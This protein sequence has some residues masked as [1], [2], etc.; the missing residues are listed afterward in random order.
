[1]KKLI[2]TAMLAALLATSAF[3]ELS[4]GTW[5]R[6]MVAPVA[7]DGEDVVKAYWGN[8]WGGLRNARAS[9]NWTSDDG[10]VGMMYDV[11]GEGSGD[12]G[13]GDYR[14][15]WVK[16]ADWVKIMVGRID[17]GYTMRSD[18]AYGSWN[19]IRPSTLGY[20]EGLT[21][22]LDNRSGLQVELFP[23]EGLQI[24]AHLALP[25]NGGDVDIWRA[26]GKSQ[27]AVGYTIGDIGTIKVGFS[28]KNISDG[29]ID[30]AKEAE[31]DHGIDDAMTVGKGYYNEK[32]NTYG[33]LQAAFDLTAVENMFLTVGAKA[34]FGYG[35]TK[36]TV[37]PAVG[38][39]VGLSDTITL[40]VS[41][42][43]DITESKDPTIKGGVGLDVGL[44]DSLGLNV[45]CRIV[46][47]IENSDFQLSF[48]VGVNY[49]FSSNGTLG[50]GFQGIA[51][52][53]NAGG[54]ALGPTV[55]NEKFGFAVP[56]KF[57]VSF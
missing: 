34:T 48:I 25:E 16:P 40:Y 49:A 7:F 5:V 41:A 1:M 24:L 15:L 17:N 56:I 36:T 12:F 30:T 57:E 13:G 53:S 43:A 52:A 51:A 8:S 42:L 22:Q 38:L 27:A 19:W 9:F 37:T 6:T 44:T 28:G 50:I 3:A 26:V 31:D 47:D 29:Y 14:A 2:G 23:V 20:D 46:D 11:F 33:T 39:R 35:G 10:K 45:D 4:I 55:Q 21:F 32:V 18:L 54:I